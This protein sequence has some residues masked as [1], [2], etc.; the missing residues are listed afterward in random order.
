MNYLELEEHFSEIE[1]M[2]LEDNLT[3]CQIGEK[4]HSKRY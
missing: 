3:P 1:K 4:F 2:Y